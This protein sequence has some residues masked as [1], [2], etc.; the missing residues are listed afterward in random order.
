METVKIAINLEMHYNRQTSLFTL[1]LECDEQKNTT[2]VYEV[3]ID[4]IIFKD[5]H[6]DTSVE[7]LLYREDSNTILKCIKLLKVIIYKFRFDV[8][9]DFFKLKSRKKQILIK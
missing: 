5:K 6:F 1:N 3:D 7:L 4:K 2:K 9:N 8:V